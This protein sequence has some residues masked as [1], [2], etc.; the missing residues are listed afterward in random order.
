MGYIEMLH[1]Y[2]EFS[3]SIRTGDLDL[4]I[5]GL[6]KITK[7]FLPLTITIMSDGLYYFTTIYWY[8]NSP[9]QKYI[10]NSKMN[11]TKKLFSRLPV[12][13]K[14]EQAINADASS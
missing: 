8:L 1:L 13:L 6:P 9:A 14:L 5:D 4:Y 7:Y 3:W 12:D 11:E 2:Q 10:K